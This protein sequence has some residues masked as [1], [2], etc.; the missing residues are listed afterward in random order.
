MLDIKFIRENQSLIEEA[1]NK[2]G[3][4]VNIDKLLELDDKRR[5][6][7]R[8]VEEKKETQ[9]KTSIK[10]AG[11][12]KSDER[13]FL[14][15][16]MQE[17]KD[18]LQKEEEKLKEILKE[19]QAIMLQVPNIPDMS[20]P[21][22]RTEEDALEIRRWGEA[23]KFDFEPKKH[24]ELM[25]ELDMADFERGV[26][27][28]GF[29][30]HFLKNDGALLLFALWKY[31]FD[32][33]L[34]KNFIPMI[35]PSLVRREPFIGTGYLPQGEE[36]LYK[37]QD[38]DY[39]SGTAEVPTM[40]YYMNEVL[41][42]KSLPIKFLSFSSCFRRE[43]GAYGKE[44]KGLFRVHEF[45]KV[46]QVALCEANHEESVKMHEEL[47]GNAEELMQGL[48]IPYRVVICAA[49]DTGLGQ[50]KKYD[51]EA[52]M[53]SE[54]KYRETH[55]CSYFHDFQTRRLNIRYKDSDGKLK[56]AHSLNNTA[57]TARAMIA[58]I[59]NNQTKEGSIIVPEALRKYIGKE[60]IKRD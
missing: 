20:V 1:A 30:G 9:N 34:S 8:S 37:T 24:T 23:P 36:D 26:K 14:I 59:E 7:I 57:I 29:R 2:K 3:F 47:L 28:A 19:W 33:L 58:I 44:T 56:Y 38:S 5:A 43:A 6:L 35:V 17:V 48:E 25:K 16:D 54:K 12:V 27:V 10:I 15:K 51:I 53:A 49:G 46:E 18:A 52:W 11:C 45:Y 4:K 40:A 21:D 50:V 13:V 55:S 22:G 39:L 41:E 60:I 31:T 32:K 42:K